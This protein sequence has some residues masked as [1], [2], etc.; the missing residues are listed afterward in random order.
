MNGFGPADIEKSHIKGI[1]G[2]Y[3]SKVWW[4]TEGISQLKVFTITIVKVV[5]E[6]PT[7]CPFHFY[8]AAIRSTTNARLINEKHFHIEKVI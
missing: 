5:R 8:A 2:V 3:L 7:H 1:L 4:N 6:W